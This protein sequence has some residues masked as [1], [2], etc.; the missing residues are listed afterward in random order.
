MSRS[1]PNQ[2]PSF[3]NM[4][5]EKECGYEVYCAYETEEVPLCNTYVDST[6][7]DA[8]HHPRSGVSIMNPSVILALAIAIATAIKDVLYT[9]NDRK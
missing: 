8:C 2:K 1:I 7:Y 4:Y 5:R 3:W 6:A 9:Y